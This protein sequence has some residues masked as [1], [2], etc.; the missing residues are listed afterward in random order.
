MNK[1]SFRKIAR[2]LQIIALNLVGVMM[3]GNAFGAS[4]VVAWGGNT[5]GEATVPAGLTNV[6]A[7]ASAS[8]HNL[9]LKSDGK[10]VAW[11][12]N[13]NGQC[14]VPP[15]L[16]NAVAIAGGTEHSLALKADGRVVQWGYNPSPVPSGLSNVVAISAGPGFSLALKQ[17][18]TVAAWGLGLNC[19]TCVPPGLSN[20]VA[21]ETGED[22]G[23]ALKSNGTVVMWGL[24]WSG[25]GI[26][27][28]ADLSNVVA[29]A[30]DFQ[31]GLALK[32]DGRVATWG[33]TYNGTGN[34]PVDL[35]NGVAIA[36][37]TWHAL[38]LKSNGTVVAWGLNS[39]GQTTVPEGLSDV[40]AVAAGAA[41]SL[42][43]VKD[44]PPAIV[45][46]PANQTTGVGQT[47]TLDV[48][49]TGSHPLTYQWRKNNSAISG[50]TNSSY[51]IA[52]AQTNHSGT[53][54]VLITNSLGSVTSSNALLTVVPVP[55]F[56]LIQPTNKAVNVGQT[57]TFWIQADG[58]P[59]LAYQWRK[60]GGNIAGATNQNYT[61]YNVQIGDAGI[62]TLLVTNAF[63]T[64]ISPDAV[65]TVVPVPPSILVQPNSQTNGAGGS[66]TFTVS[67]SGS[68]PFS[69]QWRKNGTN[70][71]D[72]GNVSGA[73][74]TSLTLSN[75]QDSD[76]A[77]YTVTIADQL[78][79]IT[80]LPATLTVISMTPTI[81][82]QP[83]G[84]TNL[85]NTL[86]TFLVTVVGS[87]PFNYQWRKD[88]AYLNESSNMSAANSATLTISN[89]QRSD[90]GDYDVV[91]TN[92]LGST[93]SCVAR[94]TFGDPLIVA[95][96]VGQAVSVGCS[97]T[98]TVA[99]IGTAPLSYQWLFN[100]N[101][102][103]SA[104][105]SSLT[106][107]NVSPSDAGFYSV[108]VSNVYGTMTSSNAL[109]FVGTIPHVTTVVQW[110]TYTSS[111]TDVPF[112]LTNVTKIAA[113]Y[114]HSMALKADG[115]VVA[116]GGNYSGQ[117]DVPAGLTNAVA[118]GAGSYHSLAVKAGG[119]VVQWGDAGYEDVPA[120][121][122]NA[123]AVTGGE[124]YSLAL[125]SNGKV[126]GWGLHPA[127][128]EDYQ[129]EYDW[130]QDTP[131][132]SLSGVT[133]IAAGQSHSLALKSNG[134]VVGWGYDGS[135]EGYDPD[136]DPSLAPDD[137]A[138]VVAIAADGQNSWAV[139]T[140][141]TVVAWGFAR[142]EVPAGLSNVVGIADH[143]ALKR[144]GTVVAWDW[145]RN[146]TY[147]PP[148]LSNVI[149][150]ARRGYRCVAL[151]TNLITAPPL[152]V[153]QPLSRTN[154]VKTIATFTVNAVAPP[155]M[156]L[157][158]Q[159]QKDGV[160][161]TDGG[162]V[163][164]ANTATLILSDVQT[165]NDGSYTVVVS[166]TGGG[167]T[168]LP[169]TLTVLDS[170]TITALPSSRTNC[171]GTIASFTV[172]A[173]GEQPLSYQW[174]K[175]G[176]VLND[177]GNASGA[178]TPNLVLS[179][180]KGND[181]ASY[182]VAVTNIFGSVTS[183]PPAGL[184]VFFINPPN[185][186][187]QPQSQTVPAGSNV[188]LTVVA[189]GS[190]GYQWFFKSAGISGAAGSS[191]TIPN[192]QSANEG[193]YRVLVTN[194]I[195]SVT[196]EIAEL[197]LDSELK[198]LNMFLEGNSNGVG[199]FQTRLIGHAGGKRVIQLSTNLPDWISIMTNEDASGFIHFTDTNSL[200]EGQRWYRAWLAP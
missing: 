186:M 80:S 148:G 5:Y 46:Q 118:I 191:L 61:I 30:S 155:F 180:V 157:G 197:Y 33:C 200:N 179:N 109:L 67:V 69:Y 192:F 64:A 96:P 66:V 159:W 37:G 183:S 11:G 182:T 189:D 174:L 86:A 7:V 158:Y 143:M 199:V 68:A 149:A 73:T 110:D 44:S 166:T 4:R 172:S 133:K 112:G 34:V 75:V 82:T 153:S 181:A 45:V 126:V 88:G 8:F 152:I 120:N 105:D 51:T 62:Y 54:A 59:P 87:A 117:T 100:G 22:N 178:T 76:V 79:S 56:I 97:A 29:I 146:W 138:N 151:A 18:G 188:T 42:A 71:T 168:S 119:S 170:P 106:L 2:A 28:P 85:A 48:L 38:A 114:Y 65:L 17:D 32:A 21:I 3:A 84:R 74:T 104:T 140:D 43:L 98:L 187:T 49:A 63:G 53:Y 115:K 108:V 124:E 23:I 78:K 25:C 89:V 12:G 99:A 121:L 9:A 163:S 177:G 27:T 134:K 52:N 102:I 77:N 128:P 194:A 196:S 131:P 31:Y 83:V 135:D 57:A 1:S 47:V 154:L 176:F 161:L 40:V 195:G 141:G 175:N 129:P 50:A 173:T 171:A 130:G 190:A 41:C 90:Q 16:T 142:G 60:N 147:V 107:T 58:T 144:D 55:P 39:S 164:G 13:W 125:R 91:I 132:S 165:T 137:A 145:Y 94:L 70:L 103:T 162:N 101:P 93:T 185:I 127:D 26:D 36:A 169:A 15:N 111:L 139:K 35:T 20:V 19:E 193:A 72:G 95:Q 92:G 14:N 10:V 24:A 6:V 113:G 167:T 122:T 136:Y 156:S 184:S 198:F 81:V 116:W 160:N 123:I 150:I